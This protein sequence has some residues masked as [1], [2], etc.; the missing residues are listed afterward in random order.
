MTTDQNE[1]RAARAL[2]A[3][4]EPG[5][6]RAAGRLPKHVRVMRKPPATAALVAGTTELRHGPASALTL[7]VISPGG[8]TG[9]R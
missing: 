4:R 8:G 5:R 7:P 3:P 2:T 9:S 1:S 6:G